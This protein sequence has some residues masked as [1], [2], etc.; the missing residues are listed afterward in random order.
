MSSIA[1][2]RI[3][4]MRL[5][6]LSITRIKNVFYLAGESVPSHQKGSQETADMRLPIRP[7]LKPAI[8]LLRQF[9]RT[10]VVSHLLPSLIL[11]CLAVPKGFSQSSHFSLPGGSQGLSDYY[12]RQELIKGSSAT[13]SVLQQSLSSQLVLLDSLLPIPDSLRLFRST[14][15]SKN[16]SF[17]LLPVSV[18]F[19]YNSHHPFGW[20][21]GPMIPAKGAQ[22]MVSGGILL[23][24]GKW[25]LQL[26]PQAIFAA[27]APFETFPTEHFDGYWSTYYRLLNNIDLPERFNSEA[28]TKFFPGQS[29][30]RYN[31]AH[32]SFGLSTENYWWGPGRFNALI[33][34]NNAP[35]FLHFTAGTR[36]PLSTPIG[37]IEAQIV[38]GQLLSSGIFPA[39]T[40]RYFNGSRLYQPKQEKNRYLAGIT[41]NWQPKWFSG[42]YL[43]FAAVSYLYR[44]EIGGTLDVLPPIGW[45]PSKSF[46]E[47][48]KAAIGSIF[49][50]Y[51]MPK[52][53]AEIYLEIAR[54]DRPVS[55][56]NLISDVDYPYAF[57]GGFR[58]LLPLRGNKSWIDCSLEITQTGLPSGNLVLNNL[59]FYTHPYV[60]QGY[61]QQGQLLGAGIGPGSNSQTIDVSW[62]KNYNRVGIRVERLARNM[63]FNY[64]AFIPTRD[65]TR[66][67]IDLSTE[68]HADWQYR[69]LL[70]SARTILTRSLN[71]QWYIFPDLGYFKN[72]Y[73]WLNFT[74]NVSVAYRL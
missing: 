63:D 62:V 41:L 32:F 12:R 45:L 49:A 19:G 17:Q 70:F 53:H 21:D 55:I 35:G 67:W 60:R 59:S 20:N 2:E 71:Y 44:D 66:H 22:T 38:A 9:G 8:G 31:T 10:P 43:G 65:Y 15:V 74:A 50:R 4:L 72:G 1:P 54:N 36:K 27:N 16:F 18:S 64:L 5:Q 42:L 46:N 57:T 37:S 14:S 56:I 33:M 48:K 13:V 40:N 23:K 6:A 61:T 52:D 30:L 39:D 58:K 29:A 7:L 24:A 47:G 3:F 26:M 73:D 34:S 68:L 25:S 28:Y 11:L 51:V 69:K